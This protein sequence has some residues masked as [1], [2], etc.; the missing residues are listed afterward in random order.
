MLHIDRNDL[1]EFAAI[2]KEL[3]NEAMTTAE[4][5]IEQGIEQGI[6]EAHLH[7]ARA[8]LKEGIPLETI[9]KITTLTLDDLRTA[10][11]IE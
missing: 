5:L 2:S 10:R 7:D 1:P 11:I 9:L 4:K 8:M 6:K 3:E